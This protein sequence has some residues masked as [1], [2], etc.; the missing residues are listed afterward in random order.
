LALNLLLKMTHPQTDFCLAPQV[1]QSTLAT[2][3]GL[4]QTVDLDLR[5]SQWASRRLL[6]ACSEL[7][8]ADR[9]RDLMLS[10]GSILATLHHAY[11]SQEFWTKC[12]VANEIP[13]LHLVG[14][15]PIPARLHLE[16]LEQSWP[17][18]WKALQGW[19]ETTSEQELAQPLLCR[20]AADKEFP[21][22]RWELVR[23]FVN[24]SSVHGG[25][26]VGMIR[27]LG[28]RPPNIDLMTYLLS[29]GASH[30]KPTA[31]GL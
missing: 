19:L 26:V 15:G 10:H 17:R 4:K 5:Y 3:S 30:E 22:A 25:Q 24:H 2:M 6:A 8:V 31:S 12:L 7:P 20:I 9:S 1:G 29:D 27:S 28:K 21:F 23:H 16:D 14:A 13:P 11:V 18:L